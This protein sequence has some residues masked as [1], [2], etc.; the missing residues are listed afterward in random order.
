MNINIR[1]LHRI[2]KAGLKFVSFSANASVS[3]L[4]ISFRSRNWFNNLNLRHLVLH[5][6][7]VIIGASMQIFSQYLSDANLDN[8]RGNVIWSSWFVI[9][10]I[11]WQMKSPFCAHWVTSF[12]KL[13]HEYTANFVHIDAFLS[14]FWCKN[15]TLYYHQ[16]DHR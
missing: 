15:G 12:I 1:Y 5:I 3:M 6:C 14:F 9:C 10:W 16:V 11:H 4:A 2:F 7:P 8:P 13:N